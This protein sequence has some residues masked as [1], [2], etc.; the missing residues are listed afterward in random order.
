MTGRLYSR[1]WVG[2]TLALSIIFVVMFFPIV[3]AK[4]GFPKSVLLTLVCLLVIWAS[5]L[6]RAYVFSGG[7]RERP[8]KGRTDRGS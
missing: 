6:V 3:Q 5:Y 4:Y 2:V 1:F 8:D 7:K